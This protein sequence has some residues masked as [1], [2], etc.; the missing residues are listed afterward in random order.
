MSW[1]RST[2][3]HILELDALKEDLNKHNETFLVE[4]PWAG[5]LGQ[6]Q[7]FYDT[8][9]VIFND[10]KIS[11]LGYNPAVVGEAVLSFSLKNFI[12]MIMKM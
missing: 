12:L 6:W 8:N 2:N 9:K 11:Q 10:K 5:N 1:K 4:F 3:K 7:W